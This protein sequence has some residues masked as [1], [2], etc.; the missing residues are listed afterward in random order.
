MHFA[1]GFL[2]N[3]DWSTK[4]YFPEDLFNEFADKNLDDQKK[5][6]G[7]FVDTAYDV[8]KDKMLAG[9]ASLEKEWGGK[10]KQYFEFVDNLF[11]GHPWPG[12]NYRAYPSIFWMFPRSVP[13]KIFMFPYQHRIP[14]WPLKVACH[15]MLHFMFFDY[16]KKQYNLNEDSPLW[17]DEQYVWRVSEVFNDVIEEWGPYEGMI[18]VYEHHKP[19]PG[20]EKLYRQMKALW[21]KE[22]DVKKL[23]DQ[24]LIS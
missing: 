16:V 19:Y 11:D 14:H 10:T 3:P 4:D 12:G 13:D 9:L 20:N 1:Y 8:E 18:G 7:D 17:G 6:L 2:E 21:T 15:E 22:P 24:I 23:L 5:I